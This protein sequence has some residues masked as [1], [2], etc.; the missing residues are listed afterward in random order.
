M[1][2]PKRS[3]DQKCRD[4]AMHFLA[5]VKGDREVVMQMADELAQ[6]IQ[7]AVETFFAAQGVIH[8]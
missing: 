8:K 4:L 3:Y 6:D 1:S 7:D 5:E 2:K